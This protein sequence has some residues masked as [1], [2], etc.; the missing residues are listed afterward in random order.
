MHNNGFVGCGT[1]VGI[2]NSIE[3]CI[4]ACRLTTAATGGHSY[5]LDRVRLEQ[6]DPPPRAG[7]ALGLGAPLAVVFRAQVAV[8][9]VRGVT[10]A[11][12]R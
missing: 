5:D 6:V 9:R 10:S 4:Y 2:Y 1:A 7:F 11:H 8:V 3:V 12:R